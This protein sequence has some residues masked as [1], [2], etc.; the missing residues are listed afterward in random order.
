MKRDFAIAISSLLGV[1]YFLYFYFA[2]EEINASTLGTLG[3][4]IGGNI[5]P[6]LTFS[7]TVLLIETLILQRRATGAAEDSARDAKETIKEQGFLIRTQI[8]ENSFFN[9]VNLCLDDFKSCKI[10]FH[11]G[12]HSGSKAYYLLVEL[13]SAR[14]GSGES[15]DEVVIG[16]DDD[17]G[18]AIYNV[19]KLFSTVFGFVLENAPEG[20]RE[21]YISL[22]TKLMPMPVIS[23]VC[24]SKLYTDWPVLKP[25]DKAGFFK[26]KGIVD[27]LKDYG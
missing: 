22:A 6:I 23:L 15:P 13:F 25:F 1:L 3:D 7:S 2:K 12:V 11:D 19:V 26:K 21:Q 20:K 14:K 24:I 9:L 5:N 18:D 16:L 8:F 27:L 10:D 17:C 4:F